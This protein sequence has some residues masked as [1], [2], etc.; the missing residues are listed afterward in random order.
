MNI[1][2]DK[3]NI[4]IHS[5]EHCE[6]VQRRL[7]ELGC[8]WQHYGTGIYQ[9]DDA[10]SLQ[11]NYHGP[12]FCI[13]GAITFSPTKDGFSDCTNITLDDLYKLP[14]KKEITVSLNTGYNAIVSVD[15]VKVG[16]NVYP[17]SVVDAL[18]K[19]QS[20]IGGKQRPKESQIVIHNSEHWKVVK[21]RLKELGYK[22]V[23]CA[24]SIPKWVY[25]WDD[26]STSWD[27][28]NHSRAHLP[29]ITLDELYS[30]KY[31][32]K[33]QVE[34]GLGVGEHRTAIVTKD[35][36]RVGCQLFDAS[37]IAKLQEAV[38]SVMSA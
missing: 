28:T 24:N 33:T 15:G 17:L 16:E 38:K 29:Y 12:S 14:L 23:P 20:E 30:E 7:F 9:K 35:H 10:K 26:K 32:G 34:V 1:R 8:Q 11:L 2:K 22:A 5:P 3:L 6:A 13:P 25:L 21:E 36:L 27:D 37:V 4:T 19:A 31:M 18:V